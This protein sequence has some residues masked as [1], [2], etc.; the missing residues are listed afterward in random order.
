MNITIV[1][2][3]FV[4]TPQ[5][6]SIICCW[7][8]TAVA[9]IAPPSTVFALAISSLWGKKVHAMT[10]DLVDQH[11]PPAMRKRT[12]KKRSE[13][14]SILHFPPLRFVQLA[15][16]VWAYTS[17]CA[18]KWNRS[19][20]VL[21][22]L[23]I[24]PHWLPSAAITGFRQPH[25]FFFYLFGCIH[26]A[27]SHATA[28]SRRNTHTRTPLC[29]ENRHRSSSQQIREES[30]FLFINC[31]LCAVASRRIGVFKTPFWSQP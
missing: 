22:F 30:Y 18:F 16:M 11:T 25:R 24:L 7:L 10:I 3:F 29:T 14:I 17:W 12:K 21:R 1:H 26:H 27:L 2:V 23:Y 19:P 4:I 8:L 9:F 13:I 28:A 5:Y 20:F 15:P 31:L 6:H